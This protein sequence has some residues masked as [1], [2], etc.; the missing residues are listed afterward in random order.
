M[1]THTVILTSAYGIVVAIVIMRIK[2]AL[3]DTHL[4]PDA[5]VGIALNYKSAW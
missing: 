4:T 3:I 2:A 1:T 5:A